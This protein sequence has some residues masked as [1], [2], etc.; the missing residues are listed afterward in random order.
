MQPVLFLEFNPMFIN[1]ADRSTH[2]IACLL[3]MQTELSFPYSVLGGD[4]YTSLSIMN[5]NYI[6]IKEQ[7]ES[8]SPISF[9]LNTALSSAE[10]CSL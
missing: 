1:K 4:S 6:N 8:E 9:C 5:K 2:K 7:G 10:Y 3:A